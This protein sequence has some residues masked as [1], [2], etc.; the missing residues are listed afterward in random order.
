[1]HQTTRDTRTLH[2]VNG[3]YSLIDRDDGFA[4]GEVHFPSQLNTYVYIPSSCIIVLIVFY[5]CVQL[6]LKLVWKAIVLESGR[7]KP[8][9]LTKKLGEYFILDMRPKH[10]YQDDPTFQLE[11]RKSSCFVLLLFIVFCFNS[12]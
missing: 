7:Q 6:Q 5:F 1:M 12:F 9:K 3:W 4:L 8:I 11:V 2:R 10:T